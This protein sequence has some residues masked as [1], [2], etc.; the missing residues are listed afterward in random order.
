MTLAQAP[1]GRTLAHPLGLVSIAQKAVPFDVEIDRIG[2]RSLTEG[3]ARFTIDDVLV[4]GSPRPPESPSP[5]TSPA[6]SSC[7]LSEQ[8]KLEGHSFE[9]FTYGVQIGSTAYRVDDRG[10]TV[11][12]RLRGRDPRAGAACSTCTGRWRRGIAEVLAAD[13]ALTLSAYRRGRRLGPGRSAALPGRGRARRDR[14]G[15]DGVVDAGT[16]VDRASV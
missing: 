7:E 4:G 3:T 9:T 15:A 14:R 2:T 13:T 11:R 12:A 5:T 10:T 6:A 1:P 8:Q 16:L